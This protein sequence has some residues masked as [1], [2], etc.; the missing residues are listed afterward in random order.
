LKQGTLLEKSTDS[1][2]FDLSQ[3]SLPSYCCQRSAF[4][5]LLP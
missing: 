1:V 5:W 4:L 2:F 3:Y